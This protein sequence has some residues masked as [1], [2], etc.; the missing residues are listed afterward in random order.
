MLADREVAAELAAATSPEAFRASVIKRDL[1]I[2]PDLTVQD[3]MSRRFQT[4]S[5]E[6]PLS[7]ALHLMVR[8][9]R[10]AVPVVS[11]NGEVL[12]LLTERELIR[13]FL[14]QVLGPAA[15]EAEAQKPPVQDVEVRDVMERTVMCLSEDQLISDVLGIM[16]SEGVAQFPVVKEGK[17][18]GF[19]SRTDIIDKLLE[20]TV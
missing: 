9:R 11:D 10:R 6:T 13:H 17:L 12:G 3:L 5:P 8:H 2:R 7:E 18:V 19:L 4:V 14:P 16:F 1:V 20:H 15:L